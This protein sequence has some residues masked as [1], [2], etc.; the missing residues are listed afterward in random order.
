MAAIDFWTTA[1]VGGPTRW[2]LRSSADNYQSA[3]ANG[4]VVADDGPLR[5]QVKV[6]IAD[7]PVIRPTL[8]P[9]E[10][11]LFGIGASEPSA[12][13]KV[14]NLQL[15]GNLDRLSQLPAPPVAT[16][17]VFMILAQQADAGVSL[18]VRANDF[19]PNGDAVRFAGVG[20][21]QHGT[22]SIQEPVIRYRRTD[23]NSVEDR[24]GYT[25]RQNSDA[26]AYSTATVHVKVVDGPI[27]ND[28]RYLAAVGEPLVVTSGNSVLNN[29]S[30]GD[31]PGARLELVSEPSATR[32]S[33]FSFNEA[34]GTF[35]I[36]SHPDVAAG[37]QV[38]FFYQFVL[39]NPQFGSQPVVSFAG[40][41]TV[42]FDN[43]DSRQ[44]IDDA[45][46]GSEDTRIEGNV[47]ENDARGFGEALSA[48]L[49]SSPQLG[50][51][52]EFSLKDNG[53]FSYRPPQDFSGVTSLVYS[54]VD[55]EPNELQK[56]TVTINVAPVNDRPVASGRSV[57]IS[58]G[59]TRTLFVEVTGSD[60]ETS[61]KD[62]E[63]FLVGT[64]AQGSVTKIAP[65]RFRYTT[66]KGGLSQNDS[67]LFYV[68]DT[69]D[70][71]SAARNSALKRVTVIPTSTTST[72]SKSGKAQNAHIEG[73]TVWLEHN[74][75][76]KLDESNVQGQTVAEPSTRTT[77]D[78]SFLLPIPDAFDT[79]G[80]GEISRNEGRLY[81]DGGTVIATGLPIRFPM[82]AHADA[83][84]ITPL[85]TL[86]VALTDDVGLSRGEAT[87][88][89]LSLLALPQFDVLHHDPLQSTLDGDPGFVSTYV[90]GVQVITTVSLL[91]GYLAATGDISDD[92][93]A[94]F[95]YRAVADRIATTRETSLDLTLPSETKRLLEVA[96]VLSRTTVVS[97]QLDAITSL[98]SEFNQR[99]ESLSPVA[100]EGLVRQ[101]AKIE[102]VALGPAFDAVIRFADG[103]IDASNLGQDFGGETLSESIANAITGNVVIPALFVEDVIG[104]EGD[105]ESLL[106]FSIRLTHSSRSPVSVH[107]ATSD[108]SLSALGGD[109][110]SATGTLVF[111]P[112]ET[113]QIVEVPHSGRPGTFVLSLD[114]AIGATLGNA[115][116]R[117]VVL[118]GSGDRDAVESLIENGGPFDGDANQDG[119][120]DA[121][122][123]HVASFIDP[124]SGS[125]ISAIAPSGVFSKA[126]VTTSDLLGSQLQS[127]DQLP[128]DAIAPIGAIH[129][130]LLTQHV[131]TTI[132][133][134][135][136]TPLAVNAVYAFR[137][138]NALSNANFNGRTGIEL[139]DN[140]HDG[141]VE[142][143][144]V[145]LP[146]ET[147]SIV[148]RDEN[149]FLLNFIPLSIPQ[150]QPTVA[151]LV[152]TEGNDLIRVRWNGQT[153]HAWASVNQDRHE[154]GSVNELDLVKIL[155]LAGSD[156]VF[157]DRS[158]PVPVW[159]EGGHGDDIIFASDQHDEILGGA[160][161][162]KIFGRGGDDR[163]EAGDGNDLVFA[164]QGN[165]LVIAGLGNDFVNGERG[166][167]VIVGGD[168]RDVLDGG[169]GDDV[170]DGG[171]G[172]DQLFGGR[173]ADRLIGGDSPDILMG[174][175]EDDVIDSG[176]GDDIADG[177]HGNDWILGREGHDRLIGN[178]GDDQ[179]FG[180]E[181]DDTISG[182]LGNDSL[183]GGSG[184]DLLKG[185]F[186][187]DVIDGGDGNDHLY[188]NRGDDSL[189]GGTGTDVVSGGLGDN[190]I[191][192][193]LPNTGGSGLASIT[194][195]E[196]EPTRPGIL[197]ND[198]VVWR[199]VNE[200]GQVTPLDALIVI[201][202][203]ARSSDGAIALMENADARLDT[204]GD[205]QVTARDALTVINYLAWKSRR[206]DSEAL[207]DRLDWVAIEESEFELRS[208]TSQVTDIA[209]ALSDALTME[210]DIDTE[211][212][213]VLIRQLDSML[214]SE[215]G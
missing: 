47:L 190:R 10:F 185:G 205:D 188:G 149:R 186:G 5:H 83:T 30:L 115:I 134:L 107:F 123:D 77:A 117:A 48:T 110:T 214:V 8:E 161:H 91:A 92:D 101:V 95:V 165:D 127:V 150:K 209:D 152:G 197:Y 105:S 41:V 157:V 61:S 51:G 42:R 38:Q 64:P 151:E 193:Q 148:D 2:E 146:F 191:E 145:H 182:N 76:G 74:G 100:G 53:T 68:R 187:D 108:E 141:F 12:N 59:T 180:D 166:D 97:D 43:A 86:L 27:A 154:I 160:G 9:I 71:D 26:N 143:A 155:A 80:D 20:G 136:Q 189:V 32:V 119:V 181:G 144:R 81:L 6:E 87:T 66:P 109:Y 158:F 15:I 69:G 58:G 124:S 99:F 135:F 137:D 104:S 176:S 203:L 46:F 73:G 133:L 18:P 52:S 200:D 128:E 49:V 169:S 23:P 84:V 70:G 78:G 126:S 19:D 111:A 67:F 132:E 147:G 116:A 204:N 125:Y 1:E 44:A 16:D 31:I 106:E 206:P 40:R 183:V 98:V 140:D 120:L 82:K 163:I 50:S 172:S 159:I 79:D 194:L 36:T 57:K 178:F 139:I 199:D 153:G 62:L 179:V 131:S 22:L 202:R 90:R 96:T 89:M 192:D 208:A 37:T 28:D 103:E 14:D 75:S 211:S 195:G 121:L 24:F 167:D 94:D 3:L 25:I 210:Q 55:K 201:N 54:I 212:V 164:G 11:R 33:Q 174:G 175:R 207:L 113:H 173:G 93:A 170:I 112:G 21:V 156:W 129:L 29:D 114:Q 72:T 196:G 177:G 168:G 34:K 198:Q 118:P 63:A 213:D 45:F 85:S 130:E 13:W 56:A 138:D 102:Q 4:R 65:K 171:H 142:A 215:H 60:I 39:D 184:N 122:Q 17:D 162:D 7:H 35:S 88:R